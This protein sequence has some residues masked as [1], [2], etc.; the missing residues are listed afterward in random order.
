MALN[1]QP[2]GNTESELSDEL[3]AMLFTHRPGPETGAGA[4]QSGARTAAERWTILRVHLLNN[5]RR[6]EAVREQITDMINEMRLQETNAPAAPATNAPNFAKLKRDTLG[7]ITKSQV[8]SL[9]YSP[10]PTAGPEQDTI[11]PSR[12]IITSHVASS[13]VQRSPKAGHRHKREVRSYNTSDPGKG[14]MV[15]INWDELSILTDRVIMVPLLDIITIKPGQ[16]GTG[17]DVCTHVTLTIDAAYDPA[18][19]RLNRWTGTLTELVL[20]VDSSR[21]A[22]RLCDNLIRV[23]T[24]KVAAMTDTERLTAREKIDTFVQLLNLPVVAGLPPGQLGDVFGCIEDLKAAID[25]VGGPA[26][27]AGSGRTITG[28]LSKLMHGRK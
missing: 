25:S 2:T 8:D 20:V 12:D 7:Q 26:K 3:E 19:K 27:R 16:S 10:A 23:R 9:L 22:I 24:A 21:E 14:F 18:Q 17:S 28:K 6:K 4:V 5:V 13:V 1:A 11:T 15:Y